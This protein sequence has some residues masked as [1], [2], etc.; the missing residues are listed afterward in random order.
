VLA[1]YNGATGAVLAEY[2]TLGSQQIA[3]IEA[4]VT[5]YFLNDSLS[6]RVV[7]N[8]SGAVIGRQAHLPYGEA[9]GVSGASDKHAFTS[10]ERDNEVGNDYAW[11][12]RYGNSTGAFLSADPY[13]A[14]G[15][16]ENP[17]RWNRYSYVLNNPVNFI[18]PSGLF[19]E[20][21]RPEF[22]PPPCLP[23]GD[24]GDQ[25]RNPYAGPIPTT[26]HYNGRQ[27]T[28]PGSYSQI[29]IVLEKNDCLQGSSFE[30]EV[31]FRFQ[32]SNSAFVPS[33]SSIRL[34]HPENHEFKLLE[35]SFEEITEGVKGK[36]RLL[37]LTRADYNTVKFSPAIDSLGY[38]YTGSGT[39]ELRCD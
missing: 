20:S 26:A 15:G 11:Q 21:P 3:K 23:F 29:R 39:I 35:W 8:A 14:S 17:Q 18:D 30:V 6:A 13:K 9:L 24:R 32:P 33:R 4:G 36:A 10:Y 5:S 22:E 25:Q 28:F 31:D 7:L 2:V 12:R 38:V 1:E 34:P 16:A 37:R 19:A 27:Y